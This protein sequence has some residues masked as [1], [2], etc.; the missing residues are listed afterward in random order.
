MNQEQIASDLKAVA[1]A[2]HRQAAAIEALV[3]AFATLAGEEFGT[4]APD[5][6]KESSPHST[7]DGGEL[8]FRGTRGG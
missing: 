4:P 5:A 1:E 7:M 2:I 3:S 8:K 6:E